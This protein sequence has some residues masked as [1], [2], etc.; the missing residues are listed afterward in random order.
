MVERRVTLDLG[1]R[2]VSLFFA[3]LF[4]GLSFLAPTPVSA[5]S[6]GITSISM[7]NPPANCTGAGCHQAASPDVFVEISGPNVLSAGEI[8]VYTIQMT[9]VIPGALLVGTGVNLSIEQGGV[10]EPLDAQLEQEFDWPPALRVLDGEVTHGAT[11]N[12]S[13]APTGGIGVFSW[14]VPLQAPPTEGIMMIS[15]ALNSFNQSF[16]ALGDNWQRDELAVYV[17]LPEPAFTLQVGVAVA[18][19][20]GGFRLRRRRSRIEPD[21]DREA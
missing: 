18:A 12:V 10:P 4:T 7:P 16:S 19:L 3:G 17:V 11:I 13:T 1:V 20:A 8:G 6:D 21:A 14:D 5:K 15:G 9:E 2:R